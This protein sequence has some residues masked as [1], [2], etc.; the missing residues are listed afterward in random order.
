MEFEHV[1]EELS[2]VDMLT[3][4][5]FVVLLDLNVEANFG[6]GVDGA[7]GILVEHLDV[8]YKLRQRHDVEPVVEEGRASRLI[9]LFALEHLELRQGE[10]AYHPVFV[11][12]LFVLEGFA[13]AEFVDIGRIV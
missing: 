3:H 2:A 8:F 10:V 13:A 12:L 7:R 4:Q 9:P 5:M 6:F 1:V 11:R